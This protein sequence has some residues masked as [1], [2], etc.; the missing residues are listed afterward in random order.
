MSRYCDGVNRRDFLRAGI[1][2]VT[3]LGLASMLQIEAAEEA[4]ASGKNAI[5][6]F[7][8]GG[9]AHQDSWDLKPDAGE[10]KGKFS[11]IATNKFGIAR[12]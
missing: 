3:G 7:L 5:F 9:Q 6:V 11:S 10:L 8:T 2:G 12:V 1:A 4:A